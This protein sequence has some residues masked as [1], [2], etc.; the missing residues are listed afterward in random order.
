MGESTAQRLRIGTRGK[1]CR[2]VLF[3]CPSVRDKSGLPFSRI[4]LEGAV[5]TL[6]NHLQSIGMELDFMRLAHDGPF[7]NQPG[8]LG[9]ER[10]SRLLREVREYVCP[11][12]PRLSSE[13]LTA[14]V[15]GAAQKV[16]K[17]RQQPGKNLRVV[18]HEPLV[19]PRLDWWQAGKALERLMA[20][21]YAL[22]PAAGGEVVVE[23]GVR[24]V[25]VQQYVEFTVRS[26]GATAL[27]I[28]ETEVFTPFLC[29]NSH[30]MGLSLVLVQQ[31]AERLHGQ[32]FFH[33]VTLCH[34][35]FTL[36]LRAHQ[37]EQ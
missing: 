36:L 33:K 6:L 32:I 17:E 1:T 16:K 20:C 29:I 22:L 24:E 4:V 30:Q 14:V 25:G 18:C 13:S 28:E 8:V 9:I 15:E 37:P 23:A 12:T 5:H 31:T 10:A 35:C 19:T 11:S 27:E 26:D 34:G 21:A 2:P 7:E 3:L